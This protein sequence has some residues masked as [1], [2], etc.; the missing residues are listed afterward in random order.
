MPGRLLAVLYVH[1]S[2]MFRSDIG[3]TKSTRLE[4]GD[5]DAVLANGL[6]LFTT[7]RDKIPEP[8]ARAPVYILTDKRVGILG[9]FC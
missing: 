7:R 1:I 4:R 9:A 5:A 8:W 3:A 2:R 6:S